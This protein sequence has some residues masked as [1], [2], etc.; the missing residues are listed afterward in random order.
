MGGWGAVAV[1][2]PLQG[3]PEEGEAGEGLRAE[4]EPLIFSQLWEEGLGPGAGGKEGGHEEWL[5]LLGGDLGLEADQAEK[6]AELL[7]FGF[8]EVPGDE[9]WG[10]LGLGELF[11][12]DF[13]E[14]GFFPLPFGGIED[15]MGGPD[16]PMIFRVFPAEQM[17]KGFH[18]R[19]GFP[20]STTKSFSVEEKFLIILRFLRLL[21][22]CRCPARIFLGYRR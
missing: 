21:G 2:A 20:D 5:L 10:I 8:S 19:V 16:I 6:V 22:F 7:G 9:V 18:G 3:F 1:A 13:E 14:E 4:L 15:G 11:G 12:K 17:D